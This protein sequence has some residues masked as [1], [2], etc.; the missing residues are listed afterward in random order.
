MNPCK[1]DLKVRIEGAKLS[2]PAPDEFIGRT[3]DRLDDLQGKRRGTNRKIDDLRS[4]SEQQW[5]KLQDETGYA[6]KALGNSFNY[7]KS[8]QVGRCANQTGAC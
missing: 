5:Q 3:K 4:A 2:N 1:D 7:V 6:W 8:R